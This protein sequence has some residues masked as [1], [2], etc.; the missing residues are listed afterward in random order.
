[1]SYRPGHNVHHIPVLR[2]SA[3]LIPTAAS[4]VFADE[5]FT[6][7]I[8]EETH[9]VSN[10]HPAALS[11]LVERLGGA[12]RWY[13]TLNYACWPNGEVRHWVNLSLGGA[14]PCVTW[15]EIVSRQDM[16]P[17]ERNAWT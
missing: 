14:T 3:S 12:C 11:A 6:L 16:R 15:E 7:R 8:G 2:Y 13:P 5:T 10:H 4:L 1:M 9:L 17:R